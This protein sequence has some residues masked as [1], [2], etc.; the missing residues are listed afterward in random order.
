MTARV[1]DLLYRLRG[2]L[3]DTRARLSEVCKFID[4]ELDRKAWLIS[5]ADV[6]KLLKDGCLVMS[7]GQRLEIIKE[8]SI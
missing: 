7:H 4:V 5:E 6:Q 8:G 1:T 3:L 2:D